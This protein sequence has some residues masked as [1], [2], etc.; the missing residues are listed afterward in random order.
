[1]TNREL[2]QLY[3]LNREI[4]RDKQRL[5]ELIAAA[6]DTSS[7][8]TGLPHA[9]GVSDK[10]ALAVEIAYLKGV[11]ESK[12]QQSYYEYNRLITYINSIEDSYIRQILTL[13]Y[14]NGLSWQQIAH[15]MGG[16]N[17]SDGV[18]M[19]CNRYLRSH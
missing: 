12:I 5:Q 11:I 8:I 17:T 3:W 2:N 6:T 1:M 16:G 7:K 13:R 10:T 9:S 19:A 14:V 18:R 4:A 15:H